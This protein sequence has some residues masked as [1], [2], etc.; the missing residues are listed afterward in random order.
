[1]AEGLEVSPQSIEAL[2]RLGTAF[3]DADKPLRASIAKSLR[4]SAAELAKEVPRLGAEKMPKRGG[5]AARL[6]QA[7]NGVTVSLSGPKV[8]VSIRAKSV[9]GYALRKIDEGF[10][11]HPVYGHRSAWVGQR[12]PAHAF[13]DAFEK[14]APSVRTALARAVQLQLDEL[15]RKAT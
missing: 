15:A 3:K 12:V 1:M 14:G 9:E 7:R 6:A 2:Q 13:S 11:R 8:S 4:A 5:L 10:V